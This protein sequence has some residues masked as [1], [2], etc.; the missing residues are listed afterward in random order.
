[1]PPRARPRVPGI[2]KLLKRNFWPTYDAEFKE[3]GNAH[4]GR[5]GGRLN[6]CR[7][8]KELRIAS[9]LTQEE[10]ARRG[11]PDCPRKQRFCQETMALLDHFRV[12]NW[13]LVRCQLPVYNPARGRRQ[14]GGAMVATSIDA[15]VLDRTTRKL[16]A[17]EIKTGYEGYF[18]MSLG[19]MAGELSS[20][21]N[22]PLNQAIMQLI[23]GMLLAGRCNRE[24][25]LP[26]AGH[27]LQVYRNIVKDYSLSRVSW[28]HKARDAI[29]RLL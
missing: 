25:F 23:G 4:G 19:R 22:C 11:R 20:V 27:V 18:D 12:C 24:H 2:L 28:L 26:A 21:G 13:E 29:T 14:R 9:G 1:M 15:V 10:I 17:L 3:S 5:F 8:D 6:G 7:V 16:L